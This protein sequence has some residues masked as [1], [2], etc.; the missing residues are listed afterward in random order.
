M[1]SV[2]ILG[3]IAAV[4]SSILY[5]P[6]VYHMIKRKST[7]DVS[8]I[9]LFISVLVSILWI[10]YGIYEDSIPLILCDT[11]ILLLTFIMISCKIYYENYYTRSSMSNGS[12]AGPR[13]TLPSNVN[14]EP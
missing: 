13:N 2:Y 10:I 8:Y 9:F 4:I 7:K 3:L 14:L 6:Q 11:I 1:D 12:T 5:V